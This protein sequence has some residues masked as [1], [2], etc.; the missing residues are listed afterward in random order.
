MT[1]TAAASGTGMFL[2]NAQATVSHDPHA[3]PDASDFTQH[4]NDAQALPLAMPAHPG[5]P[6]SPSGRPVKVEPAEDKAEPDH[7][8]PRDSGV[9]GLM[10]LAVTPQLQRVP[11]IGLQFSLEKTVRK[12]GDSNSGAQDTCSRQYTVFSPIE[13]PILLADFIAAMGVETSSQPAPTAIGSGQ[14]SPIALTQ[15]STVPDSKDIAGP[16]SPTGADPKSF[17]MPTTAPPEIAVAF[18]VQEAGQGAPRTPGS[19]IAAAPVKEPRNIDLDEPMPAQAPRVPT[20]APEGLLGPQNSPLASSSAPTTKI[21]IPAEHVSVTTVRTEVP[22]KPIQPVRD[23]SIQIGQSNQ[24]RVELRVTQQ[25][26]ELRVAVTASDP[27]LA[28]GIQQGL[29]QVLARLEEV[30]LRAE[31]WRPAGVVGSLPA[32]PEIRP[33]SAEFPNADSQQQPGPHQQYGGQRQQ[34]Q[35]HR[36]KWVDELEGDL[37]SSGQIPTGAFHGLSY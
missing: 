17:G 25:S 22:A 26:G 3:D 32:T 37:A 28:H 18:R 21:P 5:N 31:A 19:S 14:P 16:A 2:Q 29:P 30:G 6:G 34:D 36:P 27:D 4:L 10:M 11:S 24:E 15:L 12:T 33:T 35:P 8:T 9:P 23:L 7:T 13:S 20:V 1:T